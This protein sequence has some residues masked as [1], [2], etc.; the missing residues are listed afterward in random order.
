[1]LRKRS[2]KI[3]VI[4]FV[5]IALCVLALAGLGARQ[6]TARDPNL[7]ACGVTSS[8]DVAA[9]FSMQRAS[10]FRTHL[11]HAL[12]GPELDRSDPAFVV[13]FAGPRT[14]GGGG[15]P[16]ADGQVGAA[17]V[18]QNVVCVVI[19]GEPIFYSDVDTSDLKP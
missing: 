12:G 19:G 15:A 14:I 4:A 3:G 1:M 9:A 6:T 11:P 10:D 2:R 17:R 5:A 13:V 8:A 18:Y 7:L 16:A